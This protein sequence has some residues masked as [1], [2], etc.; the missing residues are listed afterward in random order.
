MIVVEIRPSR[1]QLTFLVVLHLAAASSFVLGLD[2]GF[3]GFPVGAVLAWSLFRSVVAGRR[4]LPMALA[5]NEDGGMIFRPDGGAEI[6]A[7]SDGATVVLEKALWLTWRERQG[8]T[9]RGVLLLVSDQLAPP[10]WRR[11]QVWARL[12]V[13]PA[14]AGEPGR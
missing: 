8:G 7:V 5:L 9:R 14:A 12:R 13:R 4:G 6:E 3:A 2:L 11:L 10:D 1:L